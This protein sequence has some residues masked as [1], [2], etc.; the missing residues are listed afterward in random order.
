MVQKRQIADE[1]VILI[2]QLVMQNQI[3]MAAMVLEIYFI[4]EWKLSQDVASFYMRKYFEIHY[5]DHV[6]KFR[7]RIARQGGEV[8]A[9]NAGTA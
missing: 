4:R 7:K 8:N 6:R 3:R 9:K 5:A 1:M 2:R